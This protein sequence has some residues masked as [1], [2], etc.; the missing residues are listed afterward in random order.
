M[1]KSKQKTT[2]NQTTNQTATTTPNT[3][4]WLQQPWQQYTGQVSDLMNSGQP[5]VSGP[6]ALQQQAFQGASNLTTSPLFGQ[7][8]GIAGNV[9]GAGANTT[10]PAAQSQFGGVAGTTVGPMAQATSRNFTDVDLS[11]YM[12]NGL[13]DL[14]GSAQADYDATGGRVRA[15]QA[16]QAAMNGGARNSNNMIQ[17]A[18]TEGELSRAANSGLSQLRYDAFNSAAGLAQNDLNREAST[19]QFNAGQTNQGALAQAQIDANRN[20]LEAQLG[21][22]NSQFNAGQQNAMS[23][24]NAGQMDT[25]L[26]RQLSAA[27]LL[28][29]I[30]T[31]QG[32]YERDNIALQAALGGTQ[33]DIENQTG[34]AARLAAIQALLGGVPMG[35]FVGQ[36]QTGSSNSQG[37]STG[38]QSPGL[39]GAIGQGASAAGALA[40]LFSDRRLKADIEPV[41]KDGAGR[42]WYRYRYI[43]DA[44]GTAHEGVM[45]QEVQ[46]TDPQAVGERDGFLTVDYSKLE[47]A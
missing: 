24:F 23:Q 12:N 36:T 15:A 46:A 5:V 1:S 28:S 4:S 21:L 17:S 32:A 20:S 27:G 34:E 6:S 26:A 14:L 42:Q 19:S 10:G 30:G 45:A 39:L 22:N 43:W 40:G 9:A 11:G 35:A 33:R 8:A 16:A 29:Q 41:R 31:G 3:P 37:T 44:P 47:A 2:S 13:N 7:A 25:D 18:L 38:T